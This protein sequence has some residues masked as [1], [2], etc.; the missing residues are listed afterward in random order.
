MIFVPPIVIGG[1]I[2]ARVLFGYRGG[3]PYE[4]GIPGVAYA[5]SRMVPALHSIGQNVVLFWRAHGGWF[6]YAGIAAVWLL[7]LRARAD[8]DTG[9]GREA[10]R[11][12]IAD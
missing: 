5:L 4:G 3:L 7:V 10:A 1:P 8:L 9:R 6:V 12:E 11:A 2:V